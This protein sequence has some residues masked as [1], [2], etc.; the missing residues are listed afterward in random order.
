[1]GWCARKIR[2]GQH[3]SAERLTATTVF[4]ASRRPAPAPARRRRERPRRR[5]GFPLALAALLGVG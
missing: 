2:F 5:A 3:V 4:S 1:M